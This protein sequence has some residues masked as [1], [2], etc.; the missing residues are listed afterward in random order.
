MLKY[1]NVAYLDIRK[2][3]NTIEDDT[4]RKKS[5]YR[6][7]YSIIIPLIMLSIISLISI[8]GASNI[9]QST[10]GNVLLKQ[11]MW[12]IL[13]FG[14]AYLIMFIGIDYIIKYAWHLYIIGIISLI[15]LFFIGSEVNNARCWFSIE[16]FG[17]IQPS[18][19][20]KIALI[21]VLSKTISEFNSKNTN[22]SLKD[23][24]H[25][26]L[27]IFLIIFLPCAL[28]FMQPDTGAV[29]M[30]LTITIAILFTSGI[31]YRWFIITGSIALIML[32][33]FFGLYF[34][35]SDTFIK[36]FGTDF[37]Y[38]I[39]RLLDWKNG[40]GM[41]LTNAM[42]ATGSAGL[43]GYGLNKTPIYFPEAHTDF[44]F[45]V[46]ASNFGLIG[47]ILLIGLLIFFDLKILSIG[48]KSNIISHKC[49]ISGIIG[50][51]LYQQIQSIGMNIGFL[52]IVGI[53]L[54]FI[55]YGG[56]SLLSYMII[57]GIIFCLSNQ[58]IRYFN[59]KK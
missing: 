22:P 46:Y 23:E 41:Q 43:F 15:L 44:I 19:F 59:T 50:M 26:L 35:K 13:G 58:N 16:G 18:E 7:E 39:D 4:M 37:F 10:V 24:F 9:T 29:I 20:M 11:F 1:S 42:I 53:T 48:Y 52:P 8:Y 27:R 34:I 12:Y 49:I 30:Y 25:L 36:I 32:I 38:R 54:P 17:T 40:E 33:L 5:K 31:R 28:T 2:S 51:L 45:S 6:V 14:I 57:A 47:A 3:H 56:S 21:I 55:S